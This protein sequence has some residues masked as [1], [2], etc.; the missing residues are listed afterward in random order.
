MPK[1]ENDKMTSRRVDWCI[2]GARRPFMHQNL[3]R[4]SLLMMALLLGVCQLV[5]AQQPQGNSPVNLPETGYLFCSFRGNG[6]GLHFAWS[7]DGI[8]WTALANDR[9]FLTPQI[10]G[11]LMR[12]P[13]I[14]QGP[15]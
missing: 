14:L 6:D 11:K 7:A 13:C 8:K 15:D 2:R 5:N 10:G 12:D 3:N 9:A 1:V 4:R